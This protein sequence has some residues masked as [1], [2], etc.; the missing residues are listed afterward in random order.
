MLKRLITLAALSGLCQ[1]HFQLSYPPTRGFDEDKEPTA[2][3]G[4]FDAVSTRTP[5]P[6][7]SALIK[8]A[9]E[10][11]KANVRVMISFS[12]NPTTIADFTNTTTGGEQKPVREFL[13]VEGEDICIGV[14]IRSVGYP[15]ATD[16]T[17]ATL[18]VLY[19]GGD[20]PLFQCADIVLSATAT[21]PANETCATTYPIS[22]ASSVSSGTSGA[23]S[24]T[25]S[26]ASTTSTPSG[27]QKAHVLGF[28]ISFSA[29]IMIEVDENGIPLP[30]SEL[31]LYNSP[32]QDPPYAKKFTFVWVAAAAFCV[33]LASPRLWRSLR[34]GRLVAGSRG[35]GEDFE[36]DPKYESVLATGGTD[37]SPPKARIATVVRGWCSALITWSLYSP[38]FIRLDV[39]Q[40]YLSLAQL[41]V[42]FLFATKNNIL[43][44]LM[45]R[46][47]ERLNFVHRW[48]G[49]GIFLSTTIHGGLWIKSHLKMGVDFKASKEMTGLAAYAVLGVMVLSSLRPVR[50]YMYQ[51][52]FVSHVLGF[53]SFFVLV[54]YHTPMA[55]PWIFPALAFYGLDMFL[56]LLRFRFK[57]ASLIALDNT[58][59]Q[60]TVERCDFGWIAGQHIR[61]RMLFGARVFESHPLSICNAPAPISN[62]TSSHGQILLGARVVGDWTKAINDMAHRVDEEPDAEK[63]CDDETTLGKEVMVMIDGPYG[64]ISFDLGTY[65]H[66]LLVAGGAG[67]TFT[68]GVL[69]DLVGRIVRLGRAGGERTTKIEFA[70]CIKS[71]GCIRW[72]S[73]QL[74]DIANAAA[75]CPSLD[76]HM[77][78]FVTCL[79]DPEALP[80]IPNSEVTM[81]KPSI[82]N[83]LDQFVHGASPLATRG[84]GV[85]TSGPAS[86]VD[87][88]RNS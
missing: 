59:T 71:F 5:F 65:E 88:A 51:L 22:T 34:S 41:P 64:G 19:E 81:T 84:L 62:I 43:A 3:C 29:V 53:V 46:G 74:E 78:F 75:K 70:W 25:T 21:I 12:T 87:E 85:A 54:C 15:N 55:S 58:F 56:R 16:S 63:C 14:D 82:S 38:P 45:G 76:L 9:S 31:Q 77:K 36:R 20:G 49:R 80:D 24:A 35:V 69:D 86:L 50:R 11:E 37:Y 32:L 30:P 57:P 23:A 4:G 39:G 47:Y 28:T 83:L 17:P 42:I 8:L 44:T 68:M 6:L 40:R 61:L 73:S 27:A 60:I 10:H 67:I 72:F 79:C 1:A 52:F 18:S 66:V 33:L 2:P 48:A 13:T 7:G 26:H